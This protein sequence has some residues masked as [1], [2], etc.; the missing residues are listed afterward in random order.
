MKAKILIIAAVIGLGVT[1]VALGDEIQFVTLPQVV[2][3]AVVCQ[4]NIPHYSRVT[5]GIQD[6]NG[7]YEVNGRRNTNN[8]GLYV[9]PTGSIVKRQNVALNTTGPSPRHAST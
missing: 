4:T 6:Q 2:R 9:P 5:R 7:L 8:A 1:T 3:T